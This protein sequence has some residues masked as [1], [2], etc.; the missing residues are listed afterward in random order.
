MK[1]QIQK[2]LLSCFFR[3][4]LLCLSEYNSTTMVSLCRTYAWIVGTQITLVEIHNLKTVFLSI[5]SVDN[6]NNE[7]IKALHFIL[8]CSVV[9]LSRY[10]NGLSPK[11]H[12]TCVMKCCPI[13]YLL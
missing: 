10:L 5:A 7:C 3:E 11:R 1:S 6:N 9:M 12:F 13:F 2:K 4:L 8:R